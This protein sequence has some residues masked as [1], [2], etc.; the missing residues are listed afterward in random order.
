MLDLA[1]KK[2]D[3]WKRSVKLVSAIYR[4]SSIFP[5]E[6][7]YGLTSQARRAAISTPANIAEGAARSSTKEKRRFYE[8]ARSSIAELDTH[9]EIAIELDYTNE[10]AP[11]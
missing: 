9:L 1:H 6:E 10:S 11:R 4:A 7:R 5:G 2:L 8:I 3:V